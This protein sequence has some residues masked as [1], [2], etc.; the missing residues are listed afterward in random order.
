MP[1]CHGCH[2]PLGGGS[3]NGSAPGK[4]VCSLPHHP[5]CPGG[6]VEDPNYKACPPGYLPGF[7]YTL[8][9][10]DFQQHSLM[11]SL[12]GTPYSQGTT[13]GQ[14]QPINSTPH[15]YSVTESI[16]RQMDS[17]RALNQR[18]SDN[19]DRPDDDSLTIQSLRQDPVRRVLVN[20]QLEMYREQI[21]ALSA[22]PTAQQPGPVP[23]DN[24]P[25]DEPPQVVSSASS[26][27][28]VTSTNIPSTPTVSLEN[29]TVANSQPPGFSV[30]FSSEQP[31]PAFSQVQVQAPLVHQ[32]G[33]SL[34]TTTQSVTR[35]ISS[36]PD[37]RQTSHPASSNLRVSSVNVPRDQ[38]AVSLGSYY[39]V[40]REPNHPPHHQNLQLRSQHQGGLYGQHQGPGRGQQQ[41]QGSHGFPTYQT[42]YPHG[43]TAAGYE[44]NVP[45]YPQHLAH[46]QPPSYP[47]YTAVQQF[48]PQAPHQA[49]NLVHGPRHQSMPPPLPYP[50]FTDPRDPLQWSHEQQPSQ[51]SQNLTGHSQPTPV[52]NQQPA[53][54]IDDSVPVLPAPPPGARA[55]TPVYDYFVDGTGRTC[56][57]LRQPCQRPVTRTEFRCSPQSGR[58]YSVQVPAQPV[59]PVLEKQY[60]WRCHPQ[61]GERFRVEISSQPQ[62]THGP[63][64]VAAH[65][66]AHHGLQ[67]AVASQ[68]QFPFPTPQ[69]HQVSQ[70]PGQLDQQHHNDVQ[71]IVKLCEGGVTKK[72]SKVLDFAKK[73]SVKWA[74]KATIENINLPLY[75]FGAVSE[76][77]ASMSG[78]SEPLT[79]KDTL[80]KLSHLKNILD[81][82]CLNSDSSDFM[83]YGW[84][85]AKDYAVKV[86]ASIEQKLTTWEEISG[87]IQTS[88]LLLA[89]MDFPKPNKPTKPAGSDPKKV[90][91]SRCST[92]NTCKTEGK[93]EYEVTNP[94]KKCILKHECSWCK[95]KFKQ[96]WRHQEWNCKKKN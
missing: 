8:Q 66:G 71:G 53:Q 65:Q 60:E 85:I 72:T 18:H 16:Q 43:Q 32:G 79:A 77:E 76:L 91:K 11:V 6:I 28:P 63:P 86:D 2:G 61:T 21:P 73:A 25:L 27:P 12:P 1:M 59:T 58:V 26:S 37:P 40:V 55:F 80:A 45:G 14:Y 46:P 22:A 7:E 36:H 31:V 84:T 20:Q 68:D 82:C 56:K 57:V 93:C 10:Q 67:G 49:V 33:F 78:R 5:T 13:P 87:G 4:N 3:H 41:V 96:S 39:P 83:G 38:Q 89:Q 35:S 52:Y 9:T 62:V 47:S 48:A 70:S 94:D 92:Y 95:E 44:Q 75:T 81:V 51:Y 29:C 19:P 50:M 64:Y 30:S 17:H 54:H 90:E 15:M 34:T 88:Q 24:A 23:I 74:K 42:G 69:H